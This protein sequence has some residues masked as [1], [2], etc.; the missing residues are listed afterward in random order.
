MFLLDGSAYTIS[1]NLQ[2]VPPGR[3][4]DDVPPPKDPHPAQVGGRGKMAPIDRL[5]TARS[6]EVF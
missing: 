5:S 2:T 4:A 3:S 6:K 1:F